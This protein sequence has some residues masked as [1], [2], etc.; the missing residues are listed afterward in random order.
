MENSDIKNIQRQNNPKDD[1]AIDVEVQKLLRKDGQKISQQDFQNLRH[2]YGNEELVEKIQKAYIEKYTEITKR[3]KKFAKLIRE[4]YAN[5]KYPFHILLEK[6]YK[7]KQKYNLSDEEFT[8]FQRKFESEL[9]GLQS[10]DVIEPNTNIMKVLGNVNVNLHGFGKLDDSDFKILQ[11]ILKLHATSKPLHSQVLLQSMTYE[12]CSI[13]ALTGTYNREIH[14]VANHVHPVVAALFFPKIDVLE[15]HFIHSNIA[16]IVKTRY[17]NDQFS[18][19]SDAQLYYSLSRDPNDIVCDSKSIMGDLFNR[20]QLQNQLWNSILALRNGQYYN[21]S[22]RE[23]INSIDVCRLNKYDS[24]DLIYGRNDGII[25]KRLLSAFSFRPTVVATTPIYQIFNT[26]PYQQNITPVVTYVHMINLKLPS[27][28]N[29]APVRLK[30]A[31]EQNQLFIEN[32]TIVPKHTSLIYSRGVLIFYVDRRAQVIHLNNELNP[33]NVASLP[34]AISGY[35]R[36]NDLEVDF[37]EVINIR[38]DEYQLRSVVLSEINKTHPEKNLV[39]GSST[40]CMIHADVIQGIHETE[41]FLYD[42]YAVVHPTLHKNSVLDNKPVTIIPR[43]PRL[44]D[45]DCSFTEMARKRGIV[46][47]YQLKEYRKEKLSLTF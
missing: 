9:V 14:N 3:A 44:N 46:F 42:P 11:E 23:F 18:S 45:N 43:L 40:A 8:E 31:L 41:C 36:L 27:S 12:D 26:N 34:I 30:D 22:F 25:L 35:E 20:A 39:I 1:S 13:E 28:Q 21:N 7:Y 47:I 6:A 24:P 17:A 37:G 16:N 10:P 29:N 2:K 15:T 32:G 5:T 4:K 38:E 19:V 33:Y